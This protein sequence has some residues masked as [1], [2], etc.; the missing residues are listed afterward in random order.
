MKIRPF[1]FFLFLAFFAACDEAP[2]SYELKL[3]ESNTG[4]LLQAIS[5]VSWDA[6][7]V[8]GHDATLCRTVDAGQTWETFLY[9]EADSLQF[10]DIYAL[11]EN[12][13][14]LMSAGL[15]NMSRIVKFDVAE[16]FEELYQVKDSAGFLNSFEFWPDQKT[17][18]AYGDSFDGR[19]F[20]IKT[21]DGGRHWERILTDKLP[22]AGEGEGGFAASGGC[23]AV[24]GEGLAWIATGAGGN[25]RVLFTQDYGSTWSAYDTPM[26]KGKNAG[27]ASIKMLTT[28]LGYI[29]GG[30]MDQKE[31]YTDNVAITR[32]G[33]KKW[34]VVGAP[35]TEGALYGSALTGTEENHT[36][37]VCGP[38]GMDMTT[39]RGLTYSN[40][41]TDAYWSV[42][43]HESGEF[44]FAVGPKGRIAKIERI[45]D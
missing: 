41:S 18:L 14:L 39:D 25:A 15:G 1:S 22:K 28:E 36:F 20:I 8:S 5:I 33:G 32:D 29:A 17:G 45:S 31:G 2:A 44:G 13:A 11:D 27:I 12:S 19:L 43:F 42:Q 10:R 38:R 7:W 23:I 26:V 16:G 24:M 21:N 9:K 4:A 37:A 40:V 30:N 3:Q 35:L 6:A 34:M